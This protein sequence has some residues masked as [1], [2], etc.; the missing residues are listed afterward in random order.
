MKKLDAKKIAVMAML[1]AISVVLVYLLRFPLF[2]SAPFLEYDPADIPIL[3][4]TI[5]YGPAAGLMLTV[6]A[7]A[8]QAL[9]VSAQSGV[10][11][12]IMHV[13]ATG[14]LVTVTGLIHRRS[15]SIP[16]L[17]VALVCGALSMGIVM[18]GANYIVTPLFMNSPR[19][20]VAA[21]LLPVILPFNLLKAGIN[22]SV[23]FVLYASLRSFLKSSGI[24]E[25]RNARSA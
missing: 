24:I 15:G 25:F 13:I 9:T 16:R 11:G 21:M 3:I 6:I 23:S 7:S 10:Y 4:G 12:F 18:M 20:F 8:I 19:E 14:V 17:V 1:V 2:A 22:A 5:M